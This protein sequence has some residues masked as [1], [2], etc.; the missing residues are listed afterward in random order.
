MLQI[1]LGTANPANLIEATNTGY[2]STITRRRGA[3]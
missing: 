2:S 1:L 3:P